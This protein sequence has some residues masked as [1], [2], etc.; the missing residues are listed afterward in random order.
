MLYI[1][2]NF[3]PIFGF[4]KIEIKYLTL[5]KN[6]PILEIINLVHFIYAY[7]NVYCDHPVGKLKFQITNQQITIKTQF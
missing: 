7:M 3:D 1:T 4:I 6:A 2:R 5:A